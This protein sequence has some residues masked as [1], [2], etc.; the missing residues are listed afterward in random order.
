[1]PLAAFSLSSFLHS[2]F[3]VLILALGFGF[4]IFWHELGHFLAAKWVG[5]KVEQFA[6]GFG[7]AVVS[8]RK[9]IGFRVGNTQREYDK[10][11]KE[12]VEKE[13][14]KLQLKERGTWSA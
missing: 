9:G 2:A 10:R 5:I 13:E 14:A 3:V 8:W 4:V 12:Y 7:Q 11:L 6:V 1:M